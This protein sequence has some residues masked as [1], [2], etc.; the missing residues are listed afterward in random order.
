LRLCKVQSVFEILPLVGFFQNILILSAI[1]QFQKTGKSLQQTSKS[2]FNTSSIA[3]KPS[4]QDPL[5]G[6]HFKKAH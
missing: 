5:K 6:F 1:G 3:L 2:I 4:G